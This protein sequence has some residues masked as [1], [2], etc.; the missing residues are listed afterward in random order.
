MAMLSIV[1]PVHRRAQL[2][3]IRHGTA[4]RRISLGSLPSQRRHVYGADAL[5]SATSQAASHQPGK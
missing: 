4:T 3:H 5:L 1:T 2:W